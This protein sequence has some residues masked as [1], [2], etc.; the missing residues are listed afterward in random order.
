MNDTSREGKDYQRCASP[1]A[2][3]TALPRA[4]GQDCAQAQPLSGI[5]SPFTSSFGVRRRR[6]I[7]R[8]IF[9]YKLLVLNKGLHFEHCRES[10]HEQW[11]RG[12]ERIIK[13]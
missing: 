1:A 11:C 12:R 7:L 6:L 9:L 8:Q 10:C 3:D 2:A 13:V 4:A 5:L